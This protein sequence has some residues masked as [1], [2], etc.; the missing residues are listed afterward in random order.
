MNVLLSTWLCSLTPSSVG[1]GIDGV[2]SEYVILHQDG[3]VRIPDFMSFAEASTLPVAAL[4]SYHCLFGFERTVQPGQAVLIEGRVFPL[5]RLDNGQ[6][7]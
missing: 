4:T 5:E 7:L 3:V 2:L 6:D 1:G